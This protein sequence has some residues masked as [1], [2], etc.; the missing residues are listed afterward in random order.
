MNALSMN[1]GREETMPMS[2]TIGKA[3]IGP[4]LWTAL[5]ILVAA[6]EARS[7]VLYEEFTAQPGGDLIVDAPRGAVFVMGDSGDSNVVTVEVQRWGL[8]PHMNVEIE[9][10]DNTIRV[11]AHHIPVLHWLPPF[12]WRRARFEIHVPARFD[13]D[14]HTRGGSVEVAGIEGHVQAETSG[15]SLL[16]H[17]ID[18]TVIGQT[19]GGSVEVDNCTRDV[20]V[21]TAG[22]SIHMETVGGNVVARTAGGR[23]HIFEAAG[24]VDATTVGGSIEVVRVGGEVLAHTGGGGIRARFT[25]EPGGELETVGGSIDVWFPASSGADLDARAVGGNVVV[26]HE[27][28]SDSWAEA[29]G[30]GEGSVRASLGGGGLPLRLR[31]LGGSIH[32][33]E[34]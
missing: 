34:L 12:S 5:L 33:R 32:V 15:G 11:I 1:N 4:L 19:S 6:G 8:W 2:M 17:N 28:D 24:D 21:R 25:G 13:I 10:E 22:G 27:G 16:F 26:E 23:I 9:Q 29:S 7:D 18:G 3:W 14:I 20:E 31:T 30:H